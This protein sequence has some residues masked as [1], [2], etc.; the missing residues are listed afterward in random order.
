[1]AALGS[2]KVLEK[3]RSCRVSRGNYTILG[4]G[5]MDFWGCYWWGSGLFFMVVWIVSLLLL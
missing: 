5:G 4:V 2:V 3:S 1:M